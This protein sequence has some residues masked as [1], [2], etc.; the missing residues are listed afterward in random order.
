VL[1]LVLVSIGFV[2]CKK[3]IGEQT[4]NKDTRNDIIIEEIK[5]EHG[6]LSF[7][8]VE[9]FYKALN[10]LAKDEQNNFEK[11]NK[12]LEFNNSMAEMIKK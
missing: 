10:Y 6:M 7:S 9:D 11:W 1:V 5:V 3:E 12:K 8:G 4:N 2:G